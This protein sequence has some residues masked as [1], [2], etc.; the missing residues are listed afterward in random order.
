MTIRFITMRGLRLLHFVLSLALCLAACGMWIESYR[1]CLLLDRYRDGLAQPAVRSDRGEILIFRETDRTPPVGPPSWTRESDPCGTFGDLVHGYKPFGFVNGVKGFA[2]GGFAFWFAA[3]DGVRARFLVLP[4]WA[5][6]LVFFGMT[7]SGFWGFW[8]ATIRRRRGPNAC[9][10]CGYDLRSSPTR[11]PECGRPRAA[12]EPLPTPRRRRGVSLTGMLTVGVIGT[13]F[14]LWWWSDPLRGAHY[15]LAS[16]NADAPFGFSPP[17]EDA[18]RGHDP[19]RMRR[20]DP[21]WGERW[22]QGFWLRPD[23]TFLV[24]LRGPGSHLFLDYWTVTVLDR[25]YHVVRH[26]TVGLATDAVP[27][28]LMQMHIPPENAG[29]APGGKWFLCVNWTSR[30]APGTADEAATQPAEGPPQPP[31][32][33]MNPVLWDGDPPIDDFAKLKAQADEIRVGMIAP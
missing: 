19:D 20:D 17:W 33:E 5:C 26:G 13:A 9:A 4:W 11:C 32:D 12:N 10:G 14:V 2:F 27:F 24:I 21:D 7:V 23:G 16:A 3:E 1:T 8:G 15:D 25:S 30:T 31:L 28:R 29:D 18:R 22:Y 6:V